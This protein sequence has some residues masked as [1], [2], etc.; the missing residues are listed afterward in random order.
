MTTDMFLKIVGCLRDSLVDALKADQV[1]G[2]CTCDYKHL[3]TIAGLPDKHGEYG[4][5][6]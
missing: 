2:V 5:V 1:S 3:I 4:K 6:H